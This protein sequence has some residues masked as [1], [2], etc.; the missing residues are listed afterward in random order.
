[1]IPNVQDFFDAVVGVYFEA[2]ND[3][4][5]KYKEIRTK[6]KIEDMINL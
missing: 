1:V 6:R 5:A 3:Y 4:S 2:V